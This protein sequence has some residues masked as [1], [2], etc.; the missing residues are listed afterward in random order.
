MID[1][2]SGVIHHG[3]AAAAA[4]SGGTSLTAFLPAAGFGRPGAV[5][6]L[7]R[8]RRTRCRTG[9]GG[10]RR[11]RWLARPQA[12]SRRAYPTIGPALESHQSPIELAHRD[13]Y[14]L[15]CISA[16]NFVTRPSP[17]ASMERLWSMRGGDLSWVNGQPALTA[18]L[19]HA[20]ASYPSYERPEG[21]AV[22]GSTGGVGPLRPDEPSQT[23]TVGSF[24][25]RIRA[26]R[27]SCTARER[28]ASQFST[29]RA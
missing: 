28:R 27:G 22:F 14:H 26:R 11:L 17:G 5:P 13:S 23:S 21:C 4:A 6:F 19:D 20:Q 25:W 7:L 29:L 1:H 18:A 10:N 2:A 9:G 8:S 12:R 3:G 24:P 16:N 15:P